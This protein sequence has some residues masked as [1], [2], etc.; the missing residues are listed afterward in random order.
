MSGTYR[1]LRAWQ[2]AMDLVVDIYQATRSFPAEERYGLSAQI[3]RA[4][5]SVA[6]NIAE[7]KGRSFD[8]EVVHFLS[9]SR[10]SL[11]EVETQVTIATRLGYLAEP[12]SSELLAKTSEAGRLLN[13][14]IKSLK[15]EPAA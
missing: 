15:V 9:N 10:G 4:S 13:G 5:V 6:S 11:F 2:S 14:L 8:K 3:R 7:G 1:D 12:Q